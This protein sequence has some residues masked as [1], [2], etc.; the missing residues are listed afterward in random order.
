METHGSAQRWRCPERLVALRLLIFFQSSS[1]SPH[2][3]S[4]AIAKLFERQPE[5]ALQVK[6]PRLLSRPMRGSRWATY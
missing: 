4:A 3:T 5:L 2:G 1:D 6:E